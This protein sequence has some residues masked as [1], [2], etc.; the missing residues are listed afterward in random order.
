[1]KSLPILA[2]L[3]AFVVSSVVFPASSHAL[4]PSGD[5]AGS[6][7]PRVKIVVLADSPAGRTVNVNLG[8][9]N[10]SRSVIVNW[11]DGSK[12]TFRSKCS[13]RQALADRRKCS[14]QLSHTYRK[15]GS[16]S[17][18]VRYGRDGILKA[19]KIAV[20]HYS[21]LSDPTVEL[22]SDPSPPS[23]D[24]VVAVEQWKAEMLDQ[25]NSYRSAH[26]LP[27]VTWCPALGRS[28]NGHAKYL[29]SQGIGGHIGENGSL[30]YDRAEAQ[31]YR[32]GG[33]SENY[34]MR[35]DTVDSAMNWWK[36]SPPHSKNLLNPS[37]THVGFGRS[38]SA[39]TGT[40]WVQQ[41]GFGGDCK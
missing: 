17:L 13:V 9:V 40:I 33:G 39:E 25:V 29:A 3:T 4:V 2:A 24:P 16:H 32:G 21:P 28:A 5:V 37:Y 10:S 31:G 15:N 12:S 11:G 41:F 22:P 35:V 1:M 19:K 30:P 36:N 23:P 26:G 14:K 27:A 7:P 20:S 18:L 38:E 8:M 34:V 6:I